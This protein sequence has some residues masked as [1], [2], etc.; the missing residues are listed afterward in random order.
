MTPEQHRIY[1][2]SPVHNTMTPYGTKYV[3]SLLT[4]AEKSDTLNQMLTFNIF[5]RVPT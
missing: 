4:A 3:G 1:R 5:Y 2:Y